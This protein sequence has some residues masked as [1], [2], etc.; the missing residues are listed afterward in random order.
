MFFLLKVSGVTHNSL[1]LMIDKLVHSLSII[2]FTNESLNTGFSEDAVLK[3]PW[4]LLRVRGSDPRIELPIL[5]LDPRIE[6][7]ILVVDPRISLS[8]LLGE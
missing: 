7:P 3:V 1:T 4:I 8:A 2:F 6:L 5:V